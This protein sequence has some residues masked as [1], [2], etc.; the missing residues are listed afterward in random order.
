[1]N[2]QQ[3][4]FS[5]YREKIDKRYTT[6]SVIL[7]LLFILS[8]T[9]QYLSE[10]QWIIKG[11][12]MG[13][14]VISFSVGANTIL[15]RHSLLSHLDYR[16]TDSIQRVED[17]I[18]ERENKLREMNKARVYFIFISVI[19][20]IFFALA[21]KDKYLIAIS[22]AVMILLPLAGTFHDRMLTQ[23]KRLLQELKQN[24]TSQA[25]DIST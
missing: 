16:Y 9:D 15:N 2:N 4:I 20:S 10:D 6:W 21:L 24:L 14:K 12:L 3:N 18:T 13:L 1:M 23:D 25:L 19:V 8:F 17:Y 22:G 11:L 5:P 7:G